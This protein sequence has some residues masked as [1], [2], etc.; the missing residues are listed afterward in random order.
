MDGRI[1]IDSFQAAYRARQGSLIS[2]GLHIISRGRELRQTHCVGGAEILSCDWTKEPAGRAV[3]IN[4]LFV[5]N[6]DE[7]FRR[8]PLDCGYKETR[9][10]RPDRG[11]VADAVSQLYAYSKQLWDAPVCDI[12]RSYAMG[13][14]ARPLVHYGIFRKKNSRK[15]AGTPGPKNPEP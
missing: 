2:E 13:A 11:Q 6:G 12:W 3:R 1:Q 8:M 10:Q 14:N 9:I 4:Q 15:S 7:P 5:V